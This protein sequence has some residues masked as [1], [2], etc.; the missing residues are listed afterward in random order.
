MTLRSRALLTV[1]LLS[2][3]CGWVFT[4]CSD[5]TGP[6]TNAVATITITPSQTTVPVGGSR[7][8]SAVPRDALGIPVQGIAVS[9]SSSD[10]SVATVSAAGLA[11]G[12][13]SGTVQ[14]RAT[15]GGAS[16][17]GSLQVTP[18]SA[19]TY[20]LIFSTLLGGSQQDQVR[21]LATDAQGNIYAAGGSRSPDFPTTPGAYDETP[22]GNY[23]AY[24]AKFDPNGNLIWS[25]VVGGPNYDRAYAV[26][27]DPQGYVYIAGRAGAG[28]PVTTGAFQTTFQG[29]PDVAPYGPQDGFVCKLTPDGAAVVF[30]SYFGT[31]D[32]N[33]IR[34]IAVDAQG[35]IYVAT[36]VTGTA[37]PAAWTAN[38]YQPTPRG[39]TDAVAAKI[40]TD[41]SAVL[42][43]TYVGGSGEEVSENSIRVDGSGNVFLLTTT[44]SPDA[45][46]PNGFDHSLGGPRDA[47]LVK[48]S[49]DGGTLLFGTFIGGSGGES[50]E[51]HELAIDPQGNP[52]VASGTTSTDFPVTPSAFQAQFSG[53]GGSSGGQGSNYG[54]DGFIAK[55]SGDGASLLAATY[56]GGSSGDGIEGVSADASGIYVSGATY[57]TDFPTPAGAY[58]E[59]MAGVA[60]L[61]VAK[62]SPDLST[63]I[64]GSYLG[65]SSQDYGRTS[66]IDGA[67]NVIIG[68]NVQSTDWPALN[69]WQPNAGG[70]LDGAIA[71]FGQ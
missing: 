38:G 36:S 23:D 5:S 28:F 30:C 70:L 60:D 14:I 71:K 18:G 29:S 25:T 26:E 65:G 57:S 40:A 48:I 27:V 59:T 42:W 11:T 6:Q 20:H 34:D 35:T 37:L 2:V 61:F 58:Q 1:G 13:K 43:A 69:A 49:P 24:V 16:A 33:I 17:S 51:T 9:F 47:Y 53:S 64:Y 3:C 15:A 54:G 8:F 7:R 19:S 22:N 32:H 10:T 66:T 62:L 31:T 56:L 46:T 55:I 12:R 50:I 67:G 52:V 41:G 44:N 4:A 63:M 68:G 45:A 21:D 39:G